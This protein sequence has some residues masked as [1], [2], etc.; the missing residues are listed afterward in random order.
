M[1]KILSRLYYKYKT[2]SY[3]RISRYLLREDYFYHPQ[4]KTICSHNMNELYEELC[5]EFEHFGIADNEMLDIFCKNLNDSIDVYKVEDII[6]KIKLSPNVN[7]LDSSTQRAILYYLFNSNNEETMFK[8]LGNSSAYKVYPDNY[9]VNK[10]IDA[11]LADKSYFQAAKVASSLVNKDVKNSITSHISLYACFK[12]LQNPMELDKT[13]YVNSTYLSINQP[14]FLYETSLYDEDMNTLVCR[15]ILNL[16]RSLDCN[17]GCSYDLLG[18]YLLNNEEQLNYVFNS[19][20]SSRNVVVYRDIFEIISQFDYKSSLSTRDG[21]LEKIKKHTK[22][23]CGFEDAVFKKLKEVIS[24]QEELD[25][26]RQYQIYQ[27]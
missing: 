18:N 23:C 13:S 11:Y 2:F 20:I 9:F 16:C 17:I 15:T 4:I 26:Q 22:T 12:Y 1:Y 27:K 5:H 6:F 21:I 7:L 24:E 25:V 3:R 10:V 8:I 19:I 14:Y